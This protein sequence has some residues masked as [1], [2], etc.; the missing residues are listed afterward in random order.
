MPQIILNVT[1]ELL[2]RVNYWSEQSKQSPE[3]LAIDLLEE[4]FDDCDD[5]DRLEAL[6]SS[7]QIK[8]YNANN[9]ADM[10]LTTD[11]EAGLM[12]GR[13]NIKSGNFMTL[14]ELKIACGQ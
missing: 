3:N 7:G 12:Q 1:P 14:A 6:I 8:T 9:W 10:P 13:K 4:Y 11:E 5:A 2:A